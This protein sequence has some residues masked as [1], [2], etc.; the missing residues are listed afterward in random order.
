MPTK[1]T[2]V[3]TDQ[4]SAALDEMRGEINRLNSKIEDLEKKNTDLN[5]DLFETVKIE[6]ERVRP[7]SKSAFTNLS[8]PRRT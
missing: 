7:S 2:E 4:Q 6:N 3:R 5:Q 8:S 1:V